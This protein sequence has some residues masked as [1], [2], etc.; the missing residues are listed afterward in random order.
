[1]GII[2]DPLHGVIRLDNVAQRLIDTAT[3]QR[4]RRIRQLGLASV[5]YP[6]AV[7][8]RFEHALGVYRLARRVLGQLADRGELVDVSLEE[9]RAVVLAALLHDTSHYPAAHF[10]EEYGL[11][12]ACHEK[13]AEDHFFYG[14]IGEILDETGIEDIARQVSE[15]V[16]HDGQ[17]PLGGIV[18]G[19]CD[20]DKIDYIGRDAYH[21]GLPLAFDRDR[22]IDSMTVVRVPATGRLTLGIRERGLGPFEQMLYAKSTLYREVY[23]DPTVRA[24]TVMMR[25]LVV[26]AL[27]AG[28][29]DFDE[30]KLWT[31]EEL[32]ILLRSR[33]LRRRRN[34]EQR[35]VVGRLSERIVNR[36][37]YEPVL[38]TPLSSAPS[39]SAAELGVIER[40]I[41]QELGVEQGAV[42]VDIPNR[43]GMLSTDLWV[44]RQNGDVQNARTLGPDDGFAMNEAAE[45]LYNASGRFTIF[46]AREHRLSPRDVEGAFAAAANQAVRAG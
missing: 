6:S 19:A 17:H 27:D 14:E 2:R 9:Q 32:F 42:L 5:V 10:L 7:H 34:P 30:L 29:V 26:E 11:E 8:T 43:P 25:R 37:L 24:A 1:M 3:F 13:A 45:A 16:Q 31:D 28:L 23:F 38:S 22:L 12:G 4:L 33:V 21:C 18:S 40:R 39:L 46:A 41:T 44:L 35:E 20:V 36:S 15:I